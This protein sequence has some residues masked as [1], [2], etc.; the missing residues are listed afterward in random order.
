LKFSNSNTVEE[1][2]FEPNK[3][4]LGSGRYDPDLSG[5]DMDKTQDAFWTSFDRVL[6]LKPMEV[7]TKVLEANGYVS[8]FENMLACLDSLA[9]GVKAKVVKAEAEHIKS[10][11]EFIHCIQFK[12]PSKHRLGDLLAKFYKEFESFE[13][14]FAR[15][16]S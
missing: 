13:S 8:N 3:I 14:E 10:A 5:A 11:E 4:D 16:Q 7:I 1:M 6:F 12:M 2:C 15:V 9:F